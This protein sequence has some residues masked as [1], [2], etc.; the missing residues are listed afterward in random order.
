MIHTFG[1]G[2]GAHSFFSYINRIGVVTQ[3]LIQLGKRNV[4][5]VCVCAC[6]FYYYETYLY[7][8]METVSKSIKPCFGGTR[9][10]KKER[11]INRAEKATWKLMSA[12]TFFGCKLKCGSF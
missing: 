2:S 11:D 8:D 9:G 3:V 10:R 12:A 4:L 6:L 1:E 7:Y 5:C